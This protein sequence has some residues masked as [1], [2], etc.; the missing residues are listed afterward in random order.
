MKLLLALVFF[1][2]SLSAQVSIS[3]MKFQTGATLTDWEGFFDGVPNS[4][5]PKV[6]YFIG[7]AVKVKADPE[8][9]GFIS[10]ALNYRRTDTDYPRFEE[11]F[12]L[13]ELAYSL[14]IGTRWKK[15]G[16]NLNSTVV[17]VLGKDKIDNTPLTGS[18]LEN[19]NDL[20]FSVGGQIEFKLSSR[21]SVLLEQSFLSTELYH[22]YRIERGE[23]FRKS[24]Y[25]QWTLIGVGYKMFE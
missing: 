23:R 11:R 14:G 19:V 4:Y 3:E 9:N 12:R 7:V 24:R 20:F 17:Y 5:I 6:G 21:F 1:G 25:S 16:F 13:D 22:S 2:F 10:S 18:E 15:F 8:R